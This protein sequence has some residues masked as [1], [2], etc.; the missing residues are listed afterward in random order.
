MN[1]L[2]KLMNPRLQPETEPHEPQPAG[3]EDRYKV[4]VRLW[5]TGRIHTL[6]ESCSWS[7]AEKIKAAHKHATVTCITQP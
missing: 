1:H 7:V 6:A 3:G 4:T 5:L 2:D